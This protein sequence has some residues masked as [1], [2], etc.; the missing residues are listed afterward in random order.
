MS[1]AKWLFCNPFVKV[2]LLEPS[3]P[4]PPMLQASIGFRLGLGPPKNTLQVQEP[5]SVLNRCWQSLRLEP[6]SLGFRW[7]ALKSAPPK[8]CPEE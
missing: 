3:D 2:Y 8:I 5:R 6:R 7:P 1:L 4:P